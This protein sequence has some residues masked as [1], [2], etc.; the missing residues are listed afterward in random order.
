MQNKKKSIVRRAAGKAGRLFASYLLGRRIFLPLNKGL[1]YTA[2]YGLGVHNQLSGDPTPNE[3]RFLRKLHRNVGN[4]QTILD[5]GANAGQYATYLRKVFPE[6]RILSFEPNPVAYDS[7][8]KATSALDIETLNLACSDN[9]GKAVLYDFKDRPG[10]ASAS[11]NADVIGF[12]GHTPEAR[13]I[14]TVRLDN[15]LSGRNID[16]VDFLKVDAEGHDLSVLRG[17]EAYLRDCRID[18]IQF[19]FARMNC[20]SHILVKDFFDLL[21]G[22]SIYR[23]A[24]N[25]DLLPLGS[26]EPLTC[27]LF[28]HQN[29]VAVSNKITLKI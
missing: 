21:E 18:I 13:E 25:G 3:R 2:F 10:S 23:L 28:G 9:E 24:P 17:A 6:G 20:L 16:H 22:Y 11:L 8:R 7:L 19:E 27:E 12:A 26:Y 5:V 29:L 14:Q 15:F 1:M 4:I